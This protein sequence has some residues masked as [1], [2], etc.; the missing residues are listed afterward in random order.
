[1]AGAFDSDE[2]GLAGWQLAGLPIHLAEFGALH[3]RAT[4]TYKLSYILTD[5]GMI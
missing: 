3:F 4:S 5:T 1:M 2:V